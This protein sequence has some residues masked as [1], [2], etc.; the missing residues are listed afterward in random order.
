MVTA[1]RRA[2]LARIPGLSV[3][4][5]MFGAGIGLNIRAN[6]GLSPWDAFHQG[7]AFRTPLSVGLVT[8]VVSMVVLLGWIPLRQRPG[9][10]TLLN[11]TLVGVIIDV[12]LFVVGETELIWL[13]VMYLIGGIGMVAVGSGLY[14]GSRLGPGPRDGIMTGLA[15]RGMSIRLARTL[16][17]GTVLVAGWLL[18]GAVGIGTVIYTLTIGPLLQISLRWA[19]KGPL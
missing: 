9:F 5:V 11:A 8:I 16:I 10:G 7:V 6:L 3:G 2:V 13:R 18:G 12:T 1:R 15:A 17:E 14:I 4:L 19:D